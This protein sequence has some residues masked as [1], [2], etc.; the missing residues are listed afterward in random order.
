VGFEQADAALIASTA[1][2]VDENPNTEPTVSPTALGAEQRRVFHFPMRNPPVPFTPPFTLR[3]SFFGYYNV[4][5]A[6]ADATNPDPAIK[7]RSRVRFGASLHVLADTYSH[8]GWEYFLGHALAKGNVHNPDRPYLDDYN[9]GKT[10]E[11]V[12]QLYSWLKQFYKLYYGTDPSSPL[13]LT[14]V[15]KFTEPLI[16]KTYGGF[17]NYD[18]EIAARSAYWQ[19]AIAAAGFGDVSHNQETY[20]STY[21]KD[22]YVA[23]R[24]FCVPHTPPQAGL[25]IS[26][27][28][29]GSRPA[30]EVLP[31]IPSSF[32]SFDNY[33]SYMEQ[34]TNGDPTRVIGLLVTRAA[35]LI[36][37]Q[38]VKDKVATQAGLRQLL[39][40][41]D[42]EIDPYLIWFLIDRSNASPSIKAPVFEDYMAAGSLPARLIAANELYRMNGNSTA[43]NVL[44][45][46]YEK[47][48]SAELADYALPFLPPDEGFL[49]E[50]RKIYEKGSL[51]QRDRAA[52][53]LLKIG[54]A[55][56]LKPLQRDG[57]KAVLSGK[58][59]P[60]AS[61]L[62]MSFRHNP[63]VQNPGPEQDGIRLLQRVFREHPEEADYIKPAA[64]ALRT[65]YRG[66]TKAVQASIAKTLINALDIEEYGALWEIAYSLQEISGQDFDLSPDQLKNLKS[67]ATAWYEQEF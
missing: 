4:A 16:V 13:P 31:E 56:S 57:R 51:A 39:D 2:Y 36:S 6:A 9:R 35:Y 30:E 1:Q 5:K 21:L 58:L 10:R 34:E 50:F 8:E 38:C 61:W 46:A 11:W 65:H 52:V 40:Y 67:A 45:D 60:E 49:Q 37:A 63:E 15:Q 54:T 43:K 66:Q 24:R 64:I 59:R 55:E 3:N 7:S 27:L 47:A 53:A 23:Y 19:Q 22:Y 28:G 32:V 42:K 12:T 14:E 29:D 26:T 48:G 18:N 25:A 44:I 62:L 20:E 33:C 41:S 17:D